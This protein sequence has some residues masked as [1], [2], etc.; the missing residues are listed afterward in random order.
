MTCHRFLFESGRIRPIEIATVTKNVHDSP[1]FR[2][3]LG[4]VL[5]ALVPRV[6]MAGK[7]GGLCP[8]AV[9][10]IH[11]AQ[12][13]EQGKLLEDKHNRFAL[14]VYPAILAVLHRTG[15]D[16]ET[17]GKLWGVVI[18]SLTVLPLY[19]LVRRQFDD[20]IA[21]VTAAIY[22]LHA[23]MIRWAPEGIRDPTFWFFWMLALYCLWRA[24]QEAS[25]FCFLAAGVAMA[26]AALTRFEGLLLL[27][28]MVCWIICGITAPNGPRASNRYKIIVGGF[29]T[30][31]VLPLLLLLVS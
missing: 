13:Y 5:L 20:R 23:E 28:P 21:V 17:A 10:Y 7:I 29:T 9:V 1:N 4:L 25:A 12:S 22:A 24:A 27:I 3:V 31:C 16:W 26:L 19:G 8:D 6:Y 11:I 15:I 30:L 14:N 2:V 18:S